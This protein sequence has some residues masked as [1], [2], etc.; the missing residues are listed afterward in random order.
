MVQS[1]SSS[2]SN[3]SQSK[4]THTAFKV[5]HPSKKPN[6]VSMAKA[7]KTKKQSIKKTGNYLFSVELLRI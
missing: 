7:K 2:K 4:S 6:A 1:S 5:G 3:L